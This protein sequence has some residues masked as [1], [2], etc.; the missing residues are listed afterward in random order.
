MPGSSMRTRRR[1]FSVL[2]VAAAATVALLIA[3]GFR[4]EDNAGPL[5]L[6]EEGSSTETGSSADVG[7]TLAWG[8]ITMR[9][10]GEHPLTIKRIVLH[11][12]N[13]DTGVRVDGYYLVDAATVQGEWYAIDRQ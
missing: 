13:A 4:P 8:N 11:P 1:L 10:R 9:N 2:L 7:A 3:L 6:G 12:M 5:Y